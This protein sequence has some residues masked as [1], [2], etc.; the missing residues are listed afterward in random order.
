MT[1]LINL[2]IKKTTAK[3][4]IKIYRYFRVSNPETII[5]L[6]FQNIFKVC[7]FVTYTN[8]HPVRKT[9]LYIF[10]ITLLPLLYQGCAKVGNPTGGPKDVTPPRILQSIP[11]N[12]SVFFDEKRI[13]ITF[14]EFIQLNNITQ[15]LVASPPMEEQPEVSLKGKRLVINLNTPL[16]ENTTYTLGFNNALADFHEGNV[17]AGYEYVFSTG[18]YID[19]M[20]VSGT[21]LRAFDHKVPEEPVLIMLYENLNDSTPYKMIPDYLGKT[22]KEGNFS[23]NNIKTDSFRIFALNDMNRNMLFDLP[24]EKIAFVDSVVWLHPDNISEEKIYYTDSLPISADENADSVTAGITGADTTGLADTDS[25]LPDT[26]TPDKI[27]YGLDLKMYLFEEEDLSVYIPDNKREMRQKLFIAFNRPPHDSIEISPLNFDPPE[28]WFIGEYSENLDTIVYWIVDSNLIKT[29]TLSLHVDYS[30]VDTTSSFFT[31]TD[32]LNFYYRRP[33]KKPV[34]RRKADEEADTVKTEEKLAINVNIKNNATLDLNRY[35]T[36]TSPVPPREPDPS[37]IFLFTIID[38]VETPVDFHLEKDTGFMRRYRIINKWEEST[39][40][41]LFIAPSSFTG[42]YGLS[43]DTVD[44]QFRTQQSGYYGRLIV[45]VN[46]VSHPTIVQLR[47]Q[48]DENLISEKTIHEDG[49]VIFDYLR[50]T[51]YKIKAIADSN[52]NGKWD[53]GNYLKKEQPEKVHYYPDEINIRSN[54]DLDITLDLE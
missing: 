4:K 28:N 43:N 37:G 29:D 3:R 38:S 41:G 17:L 32:T 20:S 27:I 39:K 50:P 19:S 9:A 45:N 30:T 48:N 31:Q 26:L 15:E 16:K 47:S 51:S 44:L 14:D 54:W 18:S 11:E 7:M 12:Y 36:V 46:G 23:I 24:N 1:K 13:T 6:P 49:T 10:I 2:S 35:I 40:Y 52:N 42:I 34:S 53:T 22:G 8:Y 21:L 33:V 5:S 25:L